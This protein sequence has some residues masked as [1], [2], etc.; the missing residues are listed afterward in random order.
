MYKFLEGNLADN[1]RQ[2]ENFYPV[3]VVRRSGPL[4]E[5]DEKPVQLPASYDYQGVSYILED[6]LERTQ[7]TGLLVLKNN[8]LFIERYW[9]GYTKDSL[10]VSFS[11]AKSFTSAMVGIALADNLFQNIDEAV[12]DYVPE[13]VG[14]GYDGVP[15]R[16]I[17]Q[18]CSGI[19]FVEEYD[20]E[21]ADVM[22]MRRHIESGRSIKEYASTLQ[23]EHPSGEVYNYASIDTQVLGMLLEN[24]TGVNP[25]DYLEE[26]IWGVLGMQADAKWVTDQHDTVLTYSLFNVTL[27]DYAKFGLLYLNRG[28]WNGKR[29]ISEGWIQQSVAPEKEF[30]KLKDFYSEG[31]DIGY[32]YQWWVPDG[33]EGEFTAIGIYG[34]Y[35]YVNP[36]REIVIVKTSADPLFDERDMETIA[37][38]RSISKH[39]S[40]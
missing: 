16:H 32:G 37:A 35:I 10:P 17:L 7:T 12:T 34:Q 2:L 20:Q 22:K 23:A 5:F 9:Q 21:D 18:M 8:D 39:F 6:F 31:W 3:R 36:V 27:R 33:S 29:V 26:K 4:Y 25:S 1:F 14:S 11:V 30:L 38:F 19:R 28:L 15:I 13:L 40:E 24:V